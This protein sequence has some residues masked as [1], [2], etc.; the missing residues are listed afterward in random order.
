MIKFSVNMTY[1][2]ASHTFSQQKEEMKWCN[3]QIEDVWEHEVWQL[4][5][6]VHTDLRSISRLNEQVRK[7]ASIIEHL[8]VSCCLIIQIIIQFFFFYKK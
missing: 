5:I 4:K 7:I 8:K 6:Y 1:K 3:K 2:S